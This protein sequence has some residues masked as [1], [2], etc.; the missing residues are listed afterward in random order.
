[1]S[2]YSQ[3]LFIA[4]AQGHSAVMEW[5]MNNVLGEESGFRTKVI[6]SPV[7]T[8]FW[9]CDGDPAGK[10]KRFD[11]I[12]KLL[13]EKPVNTPEDVLHNLEAASV[14]NTEWSCVYR[15]SDF[16]VQ[17]ALDNAYDKVYSL[18]PDDFR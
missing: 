17:V 6:E 8:N 7:C 1:M 5:P 11:T 13:E 9:L 15:L 10:C 14:K 12:T 18:S 3:H 16:A 2:Y 4:D